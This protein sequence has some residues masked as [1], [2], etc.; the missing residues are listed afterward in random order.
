M[1]RLSG[2]IALITGATSGIG[3]ACAFAFASQGTRLILTA[4]R[5]ERLDQIVRQLKEKSDVSVLSVKLD[6][7]NKNDV[8]KMVNNLPDAWQPIDIC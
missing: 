5:N 8:F 4:R 1:G 3:K 7:R 6:V 2:Q